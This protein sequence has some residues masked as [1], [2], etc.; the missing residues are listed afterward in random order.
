MYYRLGKAAPPLDTDNIIFVHIPVHTS[1]SGAVGRKK[2]EE[3][4]AN[5]ATCDSIYIVNGYAGKDKNGM[6]MG[7]PMIRNMKEYSTS[8]K[9]LY[10]NQS[11]SHSIE[12]VLSFY[13]SQGFS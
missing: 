7:S 5:R 2:K 13:W 6:P 10:Q 11:K 12:S 4:G 3:K 1:R 9:V 8:F